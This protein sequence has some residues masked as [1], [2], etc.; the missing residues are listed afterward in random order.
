MIRE[1]IKENYDYILRMDDDVWDVPDNA[2]DLLFSA[3]KDMISAIMYASGF[4]YQQ[5]ALVKADKNRTLSEIS[6]S[7]KG[8]LLEAKGVGV[9]PV[10]LVAMPFTL[11]KTELFKKIPEPWFVSDEKVPPDSYFC[12]KMLDNGL[13]PYAH[14]GVKVNHRGVNS[15][16]R[17]LKFISDGK[18]R[19]ALGLLKEGD[20]NYETLKGVIENIR[21]Y[22]KFEENQ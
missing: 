19:L 9:T 22:I 7:N 6:S 12:Q 11:F 5:C 15:G 16:N 8:G 20:G 14:F 18:E 3:D 21:E 17:L 4:P 2:F 10:D 13:Q 1:A